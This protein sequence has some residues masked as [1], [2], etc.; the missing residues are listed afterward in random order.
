M[1]VYSTKRRTL[2]VG[3]TFSNLSSTLM[4]FNEIIINIA[5]FMLYMEKQNITVDATKTSFKIVSQI[6]RKQ[7]TTLTE[8]AKSLELPKSTV[9]YHLNTLEEI[10]YVKKE[11]A[12]YR[13]T[14][15]FLRL[16]E[17]A[18]E[19]LPI[20]TVG[21]EEVEKLAEETNTNGYLMVEQNNVGVI[22]YLQKENNIHLGDSVGEPVHLAST[23]MGKALLAHLPEKRINKMIDQHGLP[24]FTENTITDKQDL[25]K[26][27]K[28]VE[29]CGYAINKGE[30]VA[31]LHAVAAPILGP[32]NTIRGSISL[33]APKQDMS[34]NDIET[35]YIE[36]VL[37]A[38][39]VIE[40]KLI[41]KLSDQA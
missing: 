38:A 15:R 10:G 28:K 34:E 41:R 7:G 12:E 31:G 14:L 4:K 26:E 24:Q 2:S 32:Q 11:E 40:L 5:L 30:Q 16:G 6:Q 25:F 22:L 23:A 20:Y 21:K 1:T 18:R 33:S 13:L 39:N 3:S 17:S 8:I 29:S 37:S 27:L 36:K 19:R 9:H 35:T